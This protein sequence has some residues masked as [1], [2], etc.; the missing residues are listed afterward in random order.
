M[1]RHRPRSVAEVAEWSRCAAEFGY[2]LK[3]LL[4]EHAFA[5]DGSMFTERPRLLRD[6]FPEGRVC[7]AYL[8]AVAATLAPKAGIGRPSWTEEPERYLKTP[9]FASPGP[10]MRACLLLESP[11]RFRERSLFVSANALSVA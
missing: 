3:D 8:A 2:N 10:A 11:A 1:K 5:P 7:D 6:Q 4:H 9:W